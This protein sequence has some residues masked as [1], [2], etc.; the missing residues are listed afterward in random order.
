MLI[1]FFL[2]VIILGLLL[3]KSKYICIYIIFV[4]NSWSEDDLSYRRIYSGY[5]GSSHEPGFDLLCQVCFK[6]GIPYETFRIVYVS[7]AIV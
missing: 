3:N 1:V 7:I 4:L 2:M 5:Y 6:K